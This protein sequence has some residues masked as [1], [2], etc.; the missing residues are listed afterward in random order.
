MN[1]NEENENEENENEEVEET[2]YEDLKII[3][4]AMRSIAKEEKIEELEDELQQKDEL[5]KEL[6]LQIKELQKN[7]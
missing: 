6:Y 5:I 1:E 2:L 7:K 3:R 4:R